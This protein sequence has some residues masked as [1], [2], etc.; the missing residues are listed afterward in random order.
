LRGV[1]IIKA[2]ESAG[3]SRLM[4]A[5]GQDSGVPDAFRRTQWNALAANAAR[6]E[7]SHGE[8]KLLVL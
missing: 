3:Y 5:R 2:R 8:L 7:S 1:G 6:F 4:F